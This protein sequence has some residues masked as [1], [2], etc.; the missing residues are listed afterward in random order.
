MLVAF[1]VGAPILLAGSLARSRRPRVGDARWSIPLSTE[2]LDWCA[3]RENAGP[4]LS[5]SDPVEVEDEVV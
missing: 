5:V 1:V 2:L 3:E 4:L